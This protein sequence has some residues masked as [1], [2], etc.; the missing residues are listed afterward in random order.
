MRSELQGVPGI[1]QFEIVLNSTNS[2]GDIDFFLSKNSLSKST[3]YVLS[4][5]PRLVQFLNSTIPRE[6]KIRIMYPGAHYNLNLYK[7]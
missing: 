6:H 7:K 3:F 4:T 5:N 2:P 1:V